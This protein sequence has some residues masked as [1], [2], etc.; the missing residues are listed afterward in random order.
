MITHN[1]S[2]SLTACSHICAKESIHISGNYNFDWK[3][4]GFKMC[5]PETALPA[6][7]TECIVDI[8]V[9]LPKIKQFDLPDNSLPVSAFYD[10]SA[11][12]GFGP[13]EV[14]IQHCVCTN[15]DA[16][17]SFVISEDGM[18]FQY[19][20]GG[21]FPVDSSY[22]KVSVAH[23]SKPKLG[24]VSRKRKRTHK[25][26]PRC[27]CSQLFY[28]IEKNLKFSLHFTI[29]CDLD[30][31]KTVSIVLENIKHCGGSLSK[32]IQECYRRTG[33]NCENLIIANCVF[34]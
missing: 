16:A 20:E 2:L 4:N 18:P 1:S 33:F 27:Y 31:C 32:L 15:Q 10:I 24:I 8:T 3:G 28:G 13:V 25:P 6:G 17:L 34:F 14:E 29:T 5:V 19:L 23:F 30:M 12:S 21:V 26:S 11:P 9:M 7:K 22:G